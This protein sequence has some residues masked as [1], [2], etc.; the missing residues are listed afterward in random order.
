MIIVDQ[1]DVTILSKNTHHVWLLYNV[2]RPDGEVTLVFHK[3]KASDPYH[4]HSRRPSLDRAIRDIKTH[5][6]VQLNGKELAQKGTV[7]KSGS[8]R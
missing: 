3:H 2:E 6:Q 4:T 7:N 8:T 5:D 1:Y